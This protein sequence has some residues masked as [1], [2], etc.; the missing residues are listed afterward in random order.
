VLAEDPGDLATF[1]TRLNKATCANCPSNRFITFFICALDSA[2]GEL[3]YCNAGH[4][5]PLILRAEGT[6]ERLEERGIVMGVDSAVRFEQAR[7]RLDPGD[8]LLIYSDGV[9]EAMSP[10]DEEF[11][12]QRLVATLAENLTKP[13]AAIVDAVYSAVGEWVAGAPPADDLTLIV[14]RRS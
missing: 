4:N 2:T 12:E 6:V 14:A 8:L 9:T 3:A 13:S 5:L 7:T 1:M 10:G 11:E